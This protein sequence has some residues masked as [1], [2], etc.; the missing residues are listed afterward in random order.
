MFQGYDF[1]IGIASIAGVFVGFG[2]LISI[3]RRDKIDTFQLVRI[4]TVVT[5]GLM[6]I[7]AS[8][9]PIGL[10]HYGIT[11]HTLWLICS[12]VFLIMNWTM[13]ILSLLNPEN[14]AFTLDWLRNKPLIAVPF[15]LLLELPFLIP[16]ILILID[17]YPNLELAFYTTAL[18]L[19]LFESAFVLTQIV[20]SQVNKSK[21]SK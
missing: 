5:I 11:D 2:A 12:I 10:N 20:Y 16:L 9:I 21:K 4:R 14:R 1:F 19:N 18:L 15:F 3:I 17:L 8:L 7:V 13:A 6:V